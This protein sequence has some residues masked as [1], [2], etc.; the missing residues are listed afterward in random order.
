[1]LG[2]EL[3]PCCGA[4]ALMEAIGIE[5]KQ[6]VRQHDKFFMRLAAL[7]DLEHLLIDDLLEANLNGVVLNC[8]VVLDE[9][10]EDLLER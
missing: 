7:L 3:G 4:V 10:L 5:F 6:A 2:I 9:L 1:V 8:K